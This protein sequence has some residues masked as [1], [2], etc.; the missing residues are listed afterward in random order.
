[1]PRGFDAIKTI[2]VDQI[3]NS[4]FWIAFREPNRPEF[5]DGRFHEPL[6]TLQNQGFVPKEIQKIEVGT[7]VAYLMLMSKN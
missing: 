6:V 1:M 2:D 5:A 3:T 7:E 4:Q